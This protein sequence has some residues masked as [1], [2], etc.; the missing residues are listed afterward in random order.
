MTTSQR[1]RL[2]GWGGSPASCAE[3][4]S[5]RTLDEAEAVVTAAGGCGRSLIPRGLGRS[6]GDAAQNAGGLVV[7]LTACDKILEFDTCSGIVRAEAG[8]SIESLLRQ[9]VPRGFFVP[10]T[11]GTRF[12]TIGGALAADVHGKNHHVDG[13]FGRYVRS[14][15]LATP[16]GE[17]VVT[18]DS[19]PELFWA[20]VGGMG[21]TGIILEAT[22]ELIPIETTLMTV[23][24]ARGRDLEE[25]MALMTEG[26]RSYQY[27]VAWVDCLR[28]GRALG[29]GVVTLANHTLKAAA[30]AALRREDAAGLLTY[31]PRQLLEVPI[32]PPVRLVTEATVRMFNEAWYRRAPRR[33]HGQLQLV[34]SYF[35]PLDGVGS[36][37]R[38]YGR[39]GFTQ[40]QFVVPFGAE[41]LVRKVI[42][43][44]SER[45]FP[46]PFAVLKRFGPGS[47]APL[48]FP[49]EG[50]TLALDLPLG[51]PGLA[52]E[53][54]H[55]DELVASAC[56]RVYLAKD[57]RLRAE[58]LRQMYPRLDDWQAVRDES[59]P[60]GLMVS[61]LGRRLSLSRKRT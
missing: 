46:S 10:V 34:T 57:G 16:V 6:Y 1:R 55:L 7:D 11:P 39:R 15:R 31:D 51:I 19:D 27:S 33:R 42:A 48:S 56:G 5:P 25:C 32:V 24:T 22:F 45:G 50:W 44:L 47:P 40:Y 52:H 29:R 23:D 54:D 18:P 4:A 3:V 41:D 60:G 38:L 49:I 30:E 8:L 59:D 58:M 17:R 28:G 2:T 37:N 14:I 26:D 61:D 21:L 20:T 36:W 12:V 9:S 35:H 13:S 43:R 53:L